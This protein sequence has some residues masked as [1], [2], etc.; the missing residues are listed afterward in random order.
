MALH[1]MAVRMIDGGRWQHTGHDNLPALG[2]DD[3]HVS[4]EMG[5][6]LALPEAGNPAVVYFVVADERCHIRVGRHAGELATA[7][8]SHRRGSRRGLPF[9]RVPHLR[10]DAHEKYSGLLTKVSD[11]NMTPEDS[12]SRGISPVLA[13]RRS[14]PWPL[15]DGGV[16]RRA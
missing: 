15:P 8:H 11:R 7:H 4:A 1:V 12:S 13:P 2:A 3:I 16:A 14:R 10:P 5:A 9:T 6:P